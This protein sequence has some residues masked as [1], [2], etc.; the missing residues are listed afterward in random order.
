MQMEV[1]HREILDELHRSGRVQVDDLADQLG[2]SAMTIRRDLEHLA[3]VGALRRVRGGAV[4]A[5]L[6]GEGFPFSVRAVENEDLKARL[7]AAAVAYIDDGEAVIVD[8]GTTGAAAAAEL[9]HRRVTVMP[10]SLQGIAALATSHSVNLV[11]SGGSVRGVEGTIIGP[12]AERTIA[13][14]RFDTA[15][16]TACAADPAAG[17]TAFDLGDAAIKQALVAAAARTI[18]IAEGAKFSLRSLAIVCALEDVDVLVTDSS[19]PPAVLDR[20]REAGV[21]VTVV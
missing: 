19:A 17:V 16:L 10:L 2:T 5:A 3:G 1:R 21:Q 4:G 13:S 12:I 15:I 18:L 6:H 9:A 7:A 14:L 11:L 8:S 20:L